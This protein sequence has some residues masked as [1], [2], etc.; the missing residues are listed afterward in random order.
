MS[1]EKM[2]IKD[3]PDEEFI[4]SGTRACAGCSLSIAYR[5]ALKAL[6]KNT[7]VTVPASC[8]T[9][10]HGMYPVSAVNIPMLNTAFETTGASASGIYFI[11]VRTEGQV[12]LKKV[13]L[14]R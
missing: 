12:Q 11:Q 6:G 10:L 1:G 14:I 4:L 3:I 9:V 7:I 13:M 5:H 2:V 8:S